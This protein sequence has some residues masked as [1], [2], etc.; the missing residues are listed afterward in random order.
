MSLRIQT[1]QLSACPLTSLTVL[2]GLGLGICTRL[3]DDFVNT[4]STSASLTIIFTT[5]GAHKSDETLATLATHLTRYHP[6]DVHDR[7]SFQ[8]ENVELTSLLSVR[9][10]AQ[11]LLASKLPYLNAIICNAGIGG[12]SGLNWPLAVMTVLAD[13]RR[14]TTWPEFKLGVVGLLA[15]P[16]LPVQDGK[17]SEEPLLGEVFC[18]NV[19]GHYMLAHWLM[20]LLWACDSSTPGKVV[21]IGSVEACARHY[22]SND[23]QGLRSDAAYEHGK[24]LTD[25]MALTAQ[26]QPATSKSV[27]DFLD[28]TQP[29]V[30]SSRQQ[31][32]RPTTQVTQPGIVTTTIISLYW[33]VHQAYLLSIYLSRWVGGV[34]STVKPYPA[35]ASATWVALASADEMRA[36]EAEDGGG[37]G[38][39]GTAIDPLG[40]TSIRRT[41]AEGWGINGSG[42]SYKD[43]WWGGP[44]WW[45]GGYVGRRKGAKDATKEDVD[46]FITDGAE[47]WRK[48]EGLRTDWEKRLEAYNKEQ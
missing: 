6:E 22:N 39:W 38:K 5:R 48:M 31:M 29:L 47:V 32:S 13:I 24:R 41:E 45:G 30:R 25:L 17:Q 21:W 23:H 12:W 16:Q 10:L 2:S 44:A 26:N 36:L 1:L 4:R 19:F 3:I 42:K 14:A 11:N 37:E 20:P 8:P 7:I 18:A 28:P 43:T 33:I 34:W 40:R 46:T 35:A 27:N 15:K 9:S